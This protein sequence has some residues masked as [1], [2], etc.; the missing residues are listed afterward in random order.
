MRRLG[1]LGIDIYNRRVQTGSSELKLT[2][3][4][5]SLP[6]L[7]AASAGQVVTQNEIPDAL[8]SPDHMAD[9]TVVDRHIRSLRATLKNGWK[10]PRFIETVPGHGY[11]FLAGPAEQ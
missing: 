7:L 3:L 11:R 8:R 1:D 2:D 10:K 6:Y 5:E 4:D 9:S